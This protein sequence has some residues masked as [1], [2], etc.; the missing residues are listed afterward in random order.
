MKNK[1]LYFLIA[2]LAMQVAAATPVMLATDISYADILVASTAANKIGAEVYWVSNDTIPEEIYSIINEQL[3]E[4]IYIIGG[5]AVVSEEVEANLSETYNVTRIWGMTRFG[6]SAEVAKYFWPEGSDRA[7]IAIDIFGNKEVNEYVAELISK[8]RDIALTESIPLVLIPKESIPSETEEALKELEVKEVYLVGEVADEVKSYLADLGINII[9][10]A[11]TIE[12]AEDIA[13]NASERLIIVA[14]SEWKDI[15]TVPFVPKGVALLVRNDN[16]IPSVVEKVKTLVEEGKVTDIKVVGIP[17]KAQKICDALSQENITYE[18][19][20]GKRTIIAKKVMEKIRERIEKL[21]EEYEEEIEKIKEYLE[22]KKERIEER[23]ELAYEKAN[24]IAENMEETPATVSAR[25]ELLRA[26]KEDCENVL[27]QGRYRAALKIANE[28]EHHA[29]LIMW[30]YRSEFGEEVSEEMFS[31]TQPR[32]RLI[33]KARVITQDIERIRAALKT[34]PQECREMLTKAKQLIDQDEITRAME[35]LKIAKMSCER[36]KLRIAKEIVGKMR[37]E[38]VCVQVL[39]HAVSP[40]GEC[41]VFPT[42]CDVPEGWKVVRS[43]VAQ[44]VSE[45]VSEAE[46]M[47]KECAKLAKELR[48]LRGKEGVSEEEIEEK[49]KEIR[50]KCISPVAQVAVETTST[51]RET[52]SE[53]RRIAR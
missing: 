18:C 3:P 45:K 51:I 38:R 6:T 4:E 39:T 49:I 29:K 26:L 32:K 30:Q 24:E 52:T 44:R 48:E 37:K 33:E 47:R 17:W 2:V 16:E 22:K 36:E 8:A 46:A 35:Y 7:V 53:I 50:A 21:R 42:P 12:E 9:E 10:E 27:D 34:V 15:I 19:I 14:V 1:I 11:E 20:T 28:M 41:K 23:C 43:C 40:E 13:M 25:L 31:E 5:P